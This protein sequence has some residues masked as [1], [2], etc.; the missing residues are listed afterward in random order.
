MIESNITASVRNIESFESVVKDPEAWLRQA[1][2]MLM[3]V[4][5]LT[6][7]F[8]GLKEPTRSI[9]DLDR[10]TG[11]FKLSLLA[12]GYCCENAMKALMAHKDLF[13]FNKKNGID[14]K[15]F[16]NCENGSENGHDLVNLAGLT[17]F[18]LSDDEN[19]LFIQL[20]EVIIWA[21]KYQAPIDADKLA[22]SKKKK[23]LTLSIPRDIA[24]VSAI[25]E[26]VCSQIRTK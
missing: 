10:K 9:N 16:K 7:G 2:Q 14:S 20:T 6:T 12:L 23:P 26:R 21:G 3:T 1:N 4:D 22:Q 13:I 8:V 15:S 17:N 24:A 5:I 19:N 11:S 18:E 25:Y